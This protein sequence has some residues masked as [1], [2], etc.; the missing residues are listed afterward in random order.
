MDKKKKTNK[1]ISQGLKLTITD[2]PCLQRPLITIVGLC[3]VKN[4]FSS[5]IQYSD[6]HYSVWLQKVFLTHITCFHM[7]MN[8]TNSMNM[9]TMQHNH[10]ATSCKFFVNALSTLDIYL[11]LDIFSVCLYTMGKYANEP[12]DH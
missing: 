10:L 3:P 2:E 6:I 1:K 8:T 5:F 4:K 7:Q 11:Y 12:T 9:P